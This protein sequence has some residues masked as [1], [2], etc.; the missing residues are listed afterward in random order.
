MSNRVLEVESFHS[1]KTTGQEYTY[2]AR[3]SIKGEQ[4]LWIASVTKDAKIWEIHGHIDVPEDIE[5]DAAAA[6]QASVNRQ[7]DAI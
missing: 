5:R 3:Y 2:V 4:V 1:H 7:I 6:V